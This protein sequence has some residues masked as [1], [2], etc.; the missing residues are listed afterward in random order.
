MATQWLLQSNGVIT[1]HGS[2]GTKVSEREPQSEP[3]TIAMLP[4]NIYWEDRGLKG[5]YV[6]NSAGFF[7]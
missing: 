4:P 6:V 5:L 3:L 7:L 2:I 1:K